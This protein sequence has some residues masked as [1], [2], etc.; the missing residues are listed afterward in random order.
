VAEIQVQKS[1]ES[2]KYTKRE[3]YANVCY[4]YGYTLDYVSKLPARDLYL[5]SN[6]ANKI[7]AINYMNLVN[8]SA[9]PH[10]KKGSGVN[11]LI[12]HYK[13]IIE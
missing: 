7:Q 5:L 6:T 10:T 1:K 12:K 13:G 2:K 3:L 4:H 9:S 8:I 11:K